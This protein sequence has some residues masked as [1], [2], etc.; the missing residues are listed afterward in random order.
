MRNG[1]K[2][3]AQEGYSKNFV[4]GDKK[5]LI[6]A[7]KRQIQVPWEIQVLV[8]GIQNYV[9]LCGNVLITHVFR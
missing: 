9:H 7:I 3:V 5:V 4:K 1:I 6:Q 2:A 8:R